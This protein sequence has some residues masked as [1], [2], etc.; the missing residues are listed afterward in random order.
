MVEIG[1]DDAFIKVIEKIPQHPVPVD[2][3]AMIREWAESPLCG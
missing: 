2:V 1:I 3:R